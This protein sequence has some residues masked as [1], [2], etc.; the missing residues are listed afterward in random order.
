MNTRG[1][2]GGKLRKQVTVKSN[3]LRTPNLRLTISGPVEK[4]VTIKPRH[5]RLFGNV[6]EPIKSTV[7]ITPEKKFP[8]K[9]LETKARTGQFIKYELKTE[10][11]SSGTK[12]TL[13]IE[14]TRREKGRYVD[15]I[16]LKTDNS[17]RPE[18]QVNIFGQIR[19]PQEEAAK[20]TSPPAAKKKE[21]DVAN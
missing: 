17:I 20:K 5:V 2:G 6:G 12:Y 10:Q 16:L 4:F 1:Y 18:L 11:G 13:E 14:N 8:F 21:S 9:I 3:D 19:D 7:T 15:K